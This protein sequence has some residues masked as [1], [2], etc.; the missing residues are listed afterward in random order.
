MLDGLYNGTKGNF[1][2]R[3]R[4]NLRTDAKREPLKTILVTGGAGFVGN[5]ACEFGVERLLFHSRTT[6]MKFQEVMK[7]ESPRIRR[8]Q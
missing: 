1:L 8:S 6:R 7:A 5:H 2:P 4:E 3:P